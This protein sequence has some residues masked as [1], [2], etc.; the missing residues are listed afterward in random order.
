MLLKAKRFCKKIFHY[1][2]YTDLKI[3]GNSGLVLMK[4]YIV[5][6]GL[7]AQ[8]NEEIED[9]RNQL[10]IIYRAPEI[11]LCGILRILNG[12]YRLSHCQ[13]TCKI[14]FQ[15]IYSSKTVPDFRT[16]VYYFNRNP[17]THIYLEKIL[18]EMAINHSKKVIEKLRLKSI[19]LDIDQTA[20]AIYG[21]QEG[22]KKG[23][24]AK[25]RNSKLFQTVTWSIRET[26]TIIKQEF[27]SGEKHSAKDFL[28]RLTLVVESLK[29]LGVQLRVITD[30]GYADTSVFEYLDSEGIEFLSAVK[31]FD[32]V[33][34]RGKNA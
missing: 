2:G 28:N 26:K 11:L 21:Y 10:R 32:T 17:D 14:F 33:K 27:L 23:Y 7:V 12:E 1:F 20:K 16:L 13:N 22:A 5:N 15:E 31:Q 24:S 25:D 29:K 9:K 4:D 30:S 18:F 34:K 19:T 6:I 3:I 8:F